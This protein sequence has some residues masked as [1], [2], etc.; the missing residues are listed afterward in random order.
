MHCP[1]YCLG[2]RDQLGGQRLAALGHRV[3]RGGERHVKPV[4]VTP[5]LLAG[6]EML[7]PLA[8]LHEPH[9]SAQIRMTMQLNPGKQHG[10]SVGDEAPTGQLADLLLVDRGLRGKVETVNVAHERKTGE[11]DVHL[12]L[13][14]VFARD[15]ALAEQRIE[16]DP[17]PGSTASLTR[18]RSAAG[19]YEAGTTRS[20]T[21]RGFVQAC[22]ETPASVRGTV[23]RRSGAF[24][25]CPPKQTC[26]T[27]DI[28]D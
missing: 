12:D 25:S 27:P 23:S 5:E 16:I 11:P 14:L 28:P 22:A 13:A 10:L 18:L 7:V 4:R 6:L 19:R 1:R 8:P 26:A 2:H 3:V 20:A 15:L 17:R 21:T 24:P 9:N